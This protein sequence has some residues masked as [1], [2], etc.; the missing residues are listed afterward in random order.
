MNEVINFIKEHINLVDNDY[1]VI[2]LSGGPDSMALLHSLMVLR[3]K[4]NINIVCAHINHNIRKESADEAIFVEDYCKNNNLIFEYTKFIYEDKFTESLGHEMRYKFFEDIVNKYHAKCLLTAHHGD[5]LIETV[6]MRLVRGSTLKGYAGFN[7]V[8]DKDNYKIL[9]PLISVTKDDIMKYIDNN[10]IPYVI[11]N[12]NSLTTYTRNRYRKNILPLLKEE[13]T[14]VHLKFKQFSDLIYEYSEYI[15]SIVECKYKDIVKNDVIDIYL[16]K[17]EN[18]III[19]NILQKYL[20][21]IYKD[22]ITCITSKHLDILVS[23]IK[24]DKPNIIVNLPKYN[25]IKSYNKLYL[26]LDNSKKEYNYILTDVVVLPDN[27]KIKIIDSTDKTNNYVTHLN[28]KEVKLPLYVRN[29]MVGDTMTIKNMKGHKKINDIFINEKIDIDKRE[30]YPVVVD[31]NNEIIWLPGIK[32]S[33]FDNK[34]TE[35]Y[36]IILEYY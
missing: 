16:I 9:R 23:I 26:Y 31:S 36:D 11:D 12:T 21:N 10:N 3:N 8:V 29:Y 18:E 22:D 25:F 35:N 1:V 28:S 20:H 34:N 15:D 14:N 30:G 4:I 6:L 17:Q 5:D 32:K 2:G 13:D 33:S 19:S 7:S 24:S 27:R